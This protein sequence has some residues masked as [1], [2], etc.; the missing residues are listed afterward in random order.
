MKINGSIDDQNEATRRFQNERYPSVAVTVD[1]LTTGVDVPEIVNLVFLRRVKSRILFEQMIG[2]GTRLCKGLFGEG[3]DKEAFTVWDAVGQF[4]LMGEHTT[5]QP[6]VTR[7]SVTFTHLAQELRTTTEPTFQAQ[8]RDEFLAKLR[9][10]AS[11]IEHFLAQDFEAVTGVS[12]TDFV[13][14]LA[15]G[16][17]A[18]AAALVDAAPGLPEL[19][20][21]KLPN[22]EYRQFISHHEDEVR[23][24]SAS[25][26][27]N[28]SARKTIWPPSSAT[29][30]SRGTPSPP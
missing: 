12:V 15:T 3:L 22:P 21:R 19:L 4:E 1:L 26:A 10:K 24:V 17:P 13:D 9:A 8:V 6:A 27:I 14:A 18:E 30:G 29:C 28:S 25:T 2:R 16:T 7:P 5:M 20:D 23:Q 11:R